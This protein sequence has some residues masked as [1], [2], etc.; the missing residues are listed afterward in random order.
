[1]KKAYL[2]NNHEKINQKYSVVA[3][4]NFKIKELYII[5]KQTYNIVSRSIC[6]SKLN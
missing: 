4:T 2:S 6:V 5:N 3:I 1:M